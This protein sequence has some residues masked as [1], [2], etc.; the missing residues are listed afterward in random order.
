MRPLRQFLDRRRRPDAS[1]ESRRPWWRRVPRRGLALRVLALAAVAVLHLFLF[2]PIRS[3]PSVRM[4]VGDIAEHDVRAPFA[5]RAPRPRRELEAARL[6]ASR[7]IEPLYLREAGA[8]RRSRVELGRFLDRLQQLARADS[9]GAARKRDLLKA[10]YRGVPDAALSP[11]LEMSGR[12]RLRERLEAAAESLLA[13]GIV[14]ITP[15]G[16]YSRIHVLDP[17]TGE[18]TVRDVDRVVLAYRLDEAARAE[19]RGFLRRADEVEAGVEALSYLLTPN[20]S[21]DDARTEERRAAAVASVPTE[22]EYARNERILDSGVRVNREHLAVLEALDQARQARA[23]ASDASIGLR[24]RLGRVLL[25]VSILG[26]LCLTLAGRHRR[27]LAGTGPFLVLVVLLAL[28]LVLSWICL[29][30]DVL[31]PVTVPIVMLAMLATV[32][33]G[34]GAGARVLSLIHI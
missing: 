21:Y 1:D 17:R 5:F 14:D 22:R 6:E 23:L 18:E 27:V 25:L 32:L 19:L 7:R 34:E 4:E 28:H 24:L 2:P 13:A 30:Q 16:N 10:D 31:G 29:R 15:R 33:F 9:L 26:G 3:A 11:L 20:L 8:E 12:D